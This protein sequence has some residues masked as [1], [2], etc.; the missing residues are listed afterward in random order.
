[1][2]KVEQIAENFIRFIPLFFGKM[3][4][5]N[6]SK[7]PTPKDP[8]DLTHLQF[9]VLEELFQAKTA[10]SMTQLAQNMDV[11]KQQLTPLIKHLEEHDYVRKVHNSNDRRSVLLTLTEKGMHTASIRWVEFHRIFCDRINQLDEEDLTDLD[12]AIAKIIRI[13]SKLELESK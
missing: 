4:K 8:H 1:M 7:K 11:L 9:H 5:A 12:Y 6:T 3:N 10:V 2:P 13:L